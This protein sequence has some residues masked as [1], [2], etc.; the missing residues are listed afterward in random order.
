MHRFRFFV[1]AS[2][3]VDQLVTLTPEDSHHAR[4]LRFDSS[5][6][7]E[8]V[9]ADGIVWLC[10]I[11]NDDDRTE[12]TVRAITRLEAPSEPRIEVV[13]GFLVSG[14]FDDLVNHCVQAGATKIVPWVQNRREQERVVQRA[15]RYQ[16]IVE[17][18]AKQAKRS[19]IPLVTSP[20]LGD[21]I[22]DLTPGVFLDSDADETLID[23]ASGADVNRILIGPANGI[24]PET[25]NQLA[26]NGWRGAR[27]GS[28]IMRSE[29]A[30]P[31]A[32]GVIATLSAFD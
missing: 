17:A 26:E 6:E 13:A 3:G 27:L 25:L 15:D 1:A 23:I 24:D 19:A 5:S 10:R 21:K 28:S 12:L 9:D 30:A 8:V 2:I 16:R 22:F 32:V 20:I 4:V 18:A 31:V 7:L 14:R 29:I 11:E